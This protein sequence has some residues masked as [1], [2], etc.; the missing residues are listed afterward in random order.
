MKV[1]LRARRRSGVG[2]ILLVDSSEKRRDNARTSI[3]KLHGDAPS[4]ECLV[5][6]C[7]AWNTRRSA[8]FKRTQRS[9]HF[10]IQNDTIQA[11]LTGLPTKR[12]YPSAPRTLDPGATPAQWHAAALELLDVALA[13]LEL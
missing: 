2:E 10:V 3:I 12:L 4:P 1:A 13:D 6:V 5:E 8:F 9:P 11:V 7:K